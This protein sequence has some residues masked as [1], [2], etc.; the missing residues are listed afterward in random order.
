MRLFKRKPRHVEGD[1]ILPL[2]FK[3]EVSSDEPFSQFSG[4][5]HIVLVRDDSIV[6]HTVIHTLDDETLDTV[7]RLLWK[8]YLEHEEATAKRLTNEIKYLGSY[9]PKMIGG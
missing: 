8:N 9:P 7:F 2:G 5:Y 6:E 1:L 4:E 3:F